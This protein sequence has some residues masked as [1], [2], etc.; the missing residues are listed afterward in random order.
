MVSCSSV[1]NFGQCCCAE[2]PPPK[3][4][5]AKFVQRTINLG[6]QKSKEPKDCN[7]RPTSPMASESAVDCVC[8]ESTHGSDSSTEIVTD[9]QISTEETSSSESGE[10]ATESNV[11]R[12]CAEPTL[13]T[14][15]A[16][17]IVTSQ[18]S[19]GKKYFQSTENDSLLDVKPETLTGPMKF[20]MGKKKD[21]KSNHKKITISH[22]TLLQSVKLYYIVLL[23][24]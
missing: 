13:D 11:D 9:T 16:I 1:R 23:V 6:M 22:S 10:M 20:G 12:A 21:A 19:T 14:D 3:A 2:M 8:S 15:S 5:T 4:K 17:E 24:Q 18:K 7:D